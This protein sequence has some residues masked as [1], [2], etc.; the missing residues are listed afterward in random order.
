MANHKSAEKRHRQ[1]LKRRDRNRMAKS[2]FRTA[3]K[4]AKSA[5][6]SKDANAKELLRQAEKA[7]A[8]AANKGIVHK[9]SAARR[10]SRL[11]KK[12]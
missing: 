10:I 4:K 12:K 9:K 3:I 7:I 2:G 11:T 5:V 1:S 6:E 8:K